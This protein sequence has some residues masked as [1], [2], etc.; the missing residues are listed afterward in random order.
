MAQEKRPLKLKIF[1]NE[2]NVRHQ[3][4]ADNLASKANDWIEAHL[5]NIDLDS[6][7]VN[8][9]AAGNYAVLTIVIKYYKISSN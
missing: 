1:L 7:E 5:E 9:T 3:K 6:V 4:L 8:K 2:D